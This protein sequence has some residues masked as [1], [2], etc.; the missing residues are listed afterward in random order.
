MI[1]FEIPDVRIRGQVNRAIAHLKPEDHYPRLGRGNRTQLDFF[2]D[3]IMLEMTEPAGTTELSGAMVPG[4]PRYWHGYVVLL[5]YRG[6]RFVYVMVFVILLSLCLWKIKLKLGLDCPLVFFLTPFPPDFF[7]SFIS[8]QFMSVCIVTLSRF[9]LCLRESFESPCQSFLFWGSRINFWD[10][11]TFPLMTLGI[12]L[13][14]LLLM[15]MCRK[16]YSLSRGINIVIGSGAFW[17]LCYAS[18]WGLK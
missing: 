17:A 9:L 8:L 15:Q 1:V 2:T 13:T 10:M 18:T 11:L 7:T 14:V 3:K 6:I 16:K 4:Y 12:P 5:R